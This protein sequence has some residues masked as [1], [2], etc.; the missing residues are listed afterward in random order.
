M[1]TEYNLKTLETLRNTY[2]AKGFASGTRCYVK[3]A[4]GVKIFDIDNNEYIDFAG[5]ISIIEEGLSTID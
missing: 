2:I 3:K 1:T 5:G 4:S